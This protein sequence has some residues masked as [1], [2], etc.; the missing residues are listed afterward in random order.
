MQLLR[1]IYEMK[2][3]PPTCETGIFWKGCNRQDNERQG[4]GLGC[5]WTGSQEWTRVRMQCQEH[6][7]VTGHLAG[8][9]VALGVVYLRTGGH[10]AENAQIC[11][12]IREDL[13]A[14]RQ[15]HEVLL[16]GDFN[17]HLEDLD[18]R[19]D[20]NERLLLGLASQEKLTIANLTGKCLGCFTWSMRDRQSCIDYCLLSERL[21]QRLES[22]VIDED[23]T[24]SLGS[25][26]N[27]L[28]LTFRVG[29]QRKAQ[30]PEY[31]RAPRPNEHELQNM[32]DELERRAHV[33]SS[34]EELETQVAMVLAAHTSRNTRRRR[35]KAWWNRDV[36]AAIQRRKEAS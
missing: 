15:Q 35:A 22:M 11:A 25:D 19:M 7:W 29:Q 34:Y 26:H 2:R 4:G 32:A 36:A 21:Y 33:V 8:S 30:Q 20:A 23:G 10:E 17:G 13:R 5:P 14:L 31:P 1:P 16:V 3:P 6:M 9:K 27:R 24:E 12:C 18:G 28:L